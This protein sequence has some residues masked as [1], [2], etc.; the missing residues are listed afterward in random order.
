M[1]SGPVP[2]ASETSL[3]RLARGIRA[4]FEGGVGG[5]GVLDVTGATTL[6]S[7]VAIP[8][9]PGF[10]ASKNTVDQTGIA[11]GTFTK[12]TFPTEEWDD[13]GFYDAP[14]SKWT[15]PSGLVHITG[16]ARMTAGVVD[17]AIMVVTLYKDGTR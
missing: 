7:T 17:Q 16:G 11:T 1:I 5:P 13:G 8:S 3:E 2:A 10:S 15:P 4:L 12:L 14:N 6:R 9:Q